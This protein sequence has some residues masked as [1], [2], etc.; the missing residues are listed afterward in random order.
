MAVA[1]AA[2]AIVAVVVVMFARLRYPFELEWMEGGSV[3]HVHRLLQGRPLYVAP[4]ID[5]V[6][7]TYPPLFWWTAALVARVI[8]V[9]FVSLRLVSVAA[10]LGT[11]AVIFA[12]VRR[13]TGASGIGVIAAGLY[14]ASFR[15]SGAWFDVGRVDSL[16][17]L[18]VLGSF[19]VLAGTRRQRGALGAGLLLGL[20]V[21][22]KQTALFA[23]LPL[24]LAVALVD[25][26]R[27]A[28]FAGASLVVAGATSIW[29]DVITHHWYRYF[30]L[31]ILAGHAVERAQELGFLTHDLVRN[32][33]PALAV[34]ATWVLVAGYQRLP[35]NRALR[36]DRHLEP[37]PRPSEAGLPATRS[38][39]LALHLALLL[40][41]VVGSWASRLH[42]GGYDNVLMPTFAVVAL[43]FGVA[44]GQLTASVSASRLAWARPIG[45]PIVSLLLSIAA[46]AQ[47]AVL[48]YD[49]RSQLPRSADRRAGWELVAELRTVRGPVLVASH[50]WYAVLA[51]KRPF[52]DAEAVSDVVR[53]HD[54]LLGAALVAEFHDAFAQRRFAAVVLDNPGDFEGFPADFGAYYDCSR[55]ALVGAGPN[56]FYPVTSLRI[57]P[58]RLCLPRPLTKGENLGAETPIGTLAPP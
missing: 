15:A 57:R 36:G 47:V 10:S 58:R 52:A 38:R 24:I 31:D 16:F 14:A 1:A 29:L 42:S 23:A 46:M 43:T 12:H 18:L 45:A 40:G 55:Q 39:S 26:R 30:T 51:S 5:F 22:T 20:A 35:H 49:P 54:R 8:G 53:S 44:A 28:A 48:A 25:R 32:L 56:A 50:P 11:L 3:E 33:F 17:V 34:V 9:G 6:N 19:A 13:E 4:S 37:A 2:T 27:F 41:L 7:Y 21:L